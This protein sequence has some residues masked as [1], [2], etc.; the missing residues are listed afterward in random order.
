LKGRDHSEDIG[1]DGRM[2]VEWILKKQDGKMWT[3][4][5]CLRTGNSGGLL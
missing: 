4:F 5:I 1:I 3:G 2:I